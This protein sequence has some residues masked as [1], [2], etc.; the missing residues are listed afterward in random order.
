VR[1]LDERADVEAGWRTYVVS[2]EGKLLLAP[3]RSEHIACAA[4]RDVLA[5][6]EIR[7]DAAGTVL[8]V[9]NYSTGFC[10]PETCWEPLRTA[11]DNA[12]IV[13]P[14]GFTFTA[15]FRRC[16]ECGERNLVKDEWY[17]CALCNA[18]LSTFWNFD[19]Q[20][21]SGRGGECQ[22]SRCLK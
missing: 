8:E 9:T 21:A 4:G 5:A 3:R 10:P 12:G 15:R 17:V 16:P 14:N 6:G 19:D 7:F 18:D 22:A 11:L 20:E 1:W 13:R 2:L